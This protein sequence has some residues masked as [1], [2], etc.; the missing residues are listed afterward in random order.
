MLVL[1]VLNVD[2]AVGDVMLTVG[3]VVSVCCGVVTASTAL[4]VLPALS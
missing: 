4:D 3:G 1:E 2:A